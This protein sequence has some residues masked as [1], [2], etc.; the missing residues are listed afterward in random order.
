[1]DVFIKVQFGV[2]LSYF[3][4]FNFAKNNKLDLRYKLLNLYQ[5]DLK[6]EPYVLSKNS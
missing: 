6:T 5:K 4:L 2:I 3:N 1:M